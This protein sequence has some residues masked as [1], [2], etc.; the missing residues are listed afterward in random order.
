MESFNTS[1][2]SVQ[3]QS[4]SIRKAFIR[5]QYILCFGSSFLELGYDSDDFLV[6]IHP[7]FQFK[8]NWSWTCWNW[9]QVSIHPMFRFKATNQ[10]GLDASTLCF[11]TSYVSVQG[12]FILL[13][14]HISKCFNTSYV[15]VQVNMFSIFKSFERGFNTSYV[16]VQAR[17][18]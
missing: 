10:L 2:V 7:M 5:F 15:S 8:W 13:F 17:K 16:S 6:S 11:N 3:G 4:E 12:L 9:K 1:Y 18:E 14:L